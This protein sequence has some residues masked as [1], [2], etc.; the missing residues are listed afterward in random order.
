MSI[1]GG[2]EALLRDV[3]A[4]CLEDFPRWLKE[5]E[6]GL[7]EQ[8]AL[9]FRRAAHS[10][11]GACRTFGWDRLTASTQELETLALAGNLAAAETLLNSLQPELQ[12]CRT[13]LQEFLAKP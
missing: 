8:Q 10:V 3:A 2:D 1:V 5:F 7:A 6:Q 9:V 11:R 13:E 12:A 4:A